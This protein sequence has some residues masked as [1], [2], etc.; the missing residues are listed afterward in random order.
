[1][2]SPN[3]PFDEIVAVAERLHAEGR[4]SVRQL[5]EEVGGGERDR[6]VRAARQVREAADGTAPSVAVEAQP[7]AAELPEAVRTCLGRLE[8]VVLNEVRSARTQE[9][10]RARLTEAAAA[11]AHQEQI[12]VAETRIAL[13]Q[14][15]I[16]EAETEV[17]RLREACAGLEADLVR[18][19]TAREDLECTRK[20]EAEQKSLERL[21][22]AEALS[23]A[24]EDA[25]ANAASRASA[26]AAAAAAQ[27]AA[28]SAQAT[29]AAISAEID[30]VR[31]ECT[32]LRN[33][34]EELVRLLSKAE[35]E[36]N[37]ALA[38]LREAQGTTVREAD[39]GEAGAS[40]GR[41]RL[42]KQP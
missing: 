17:V 37:R 23:H 30:R 24:R 8:V 19:R 28:S 34:N 27:A 9:I 35:V 20:R 39:Q 32:Q 15:D 5:K 11:T 10:E 25:S 13:L 18:E 12:R 1:M 14:E 29:A 4:L 22:L 2:R 6:L 16:E 21:T 41:S 31:S 3:V 38:D 36:R 42:R 7:E 33:R 40:A 26:D